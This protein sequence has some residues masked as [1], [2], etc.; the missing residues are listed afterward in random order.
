M[1]LVVGA[2]GEVSQDLHDLIQKLAESKANATGLRRG[3][4]GAEE[5][6]FIIVGQIR[7]AVS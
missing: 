4:E 7:Q 3:R 2:F 5:D 1:G 6:I